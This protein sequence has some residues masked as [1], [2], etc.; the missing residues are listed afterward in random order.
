M[1]QIFAP[2]GLPASL[3]SCAGSLAFRTLGIGV[4]MNVSCRECIQIPA[5]SVAM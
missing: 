3:V 4:F 1:M 5:E 2:E